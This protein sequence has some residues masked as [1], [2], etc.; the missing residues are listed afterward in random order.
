MAKGFKCPS[1]GVQKCEDLGSHLYCPDCKS[2][3]W[4]LNNSKFEGGKGKGNTCHHCGK[5][6]LHNITNM[7]TDSVIIKI[8]RCSTCHAVLIKKE[9]INKD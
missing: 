9:S 7:D 5:F 8:F 6:T 3:F 2:I 4:D 1:C